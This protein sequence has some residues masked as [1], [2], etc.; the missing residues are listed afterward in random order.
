MRLTGWLMALALV[1]ACSATDD[2]TTFAAPDEPAPASPMPATV[3]AQPVPAPPENPRSP[4][5]VLVLMDDFSMDLLQ[6]MRSA[7]RMQRLGASYRH[8]YVVDSLC[9]VSRASLLTGQYPH[10]TGVLTNTA[11]TPNR[12]GPVGGWEAF[13]TY[14]NGRRSVNVRLRDAGYRTGYIGKYLNQ[15]ELRPNQPTPVPPP[16]WTDW[17]VFFGSAYDGWDFWSTETRDDGT[18]VPRFHE[19]APAWAPDVEKDA[20]YATN[21]MA[22]Q[23]LEFIEDSAED[24]SP[25]FLEIAP[26]GPH[27]RV[28][29]YPHYEGDPRYPPAFADRPGHGRKGGNCG[30]VRCADLDIEDL[31]GFDDD[32]TDN[33]PRWK[34]GTVAPAWRTNEQRLTRGMAVSGLRNRARMV[35]SIDRMVTDV[36]DAVDDNTYVVLTSDNGFHLG[37]HQLGGGKGTPYESDVHVPLLVVGPGV[38]PGE[39]Q[40]MVSNLDLA[41]TFE[42]LAGLEPARYRSGLSFVPTL[43][44]QR[45][46]RRGH[47]VF[48]HTWAPTLGSDPDRGYAG[49]TLDIIPSYVAARNRKGLLVRVDLDNSWE[50]TRYAWEFYDYREDAFER[51]NSFADPDNAEEI[52]RLRGV[53]DRFDRCAKHTRNKAVPSHCRWL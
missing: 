6:T 8:A 10:Q 48:E 39:R 17:Q 40:E 21:V 28:N 43:R 15:Y 3:R 4:N 36:L 35:A 29:P 51:R 44:D 7:E 14:G 23:A 26:F 37:Q 22:D 2:P 30:L 45:I 12:F 34:D 18:V 1:A 27:A 16:G 31:V 47:V 46:N 50:G 42:H 49:G 19:A 33:A 41:P 5:I 24:G 52:T 32:R 11:N 13:D 38:E 25:Y 20:T 53:I 9:C